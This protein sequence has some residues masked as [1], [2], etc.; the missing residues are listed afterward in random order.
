MGVIEAPRGQTYPTVGH[1]LTL[2]SG[3]ITPPPTYAS[4][5]V[6]DQ[7]TKKRPPGLL[8]GDLVVLWC[9]VTRFSRLGARGRW[10]F[11]QS[12]D[13]PNGYRTHRDTGALRQILSPT[14]SYVS[15]ALVAWLLNLGFVAGLSTQPRLLRILYLQRAGCQGRFYLDHRSIPVFLIFCS[16]F[17]R[18]RCC[19][20]SLKSL[21]SARCP[22]FS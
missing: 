1:L 2:I 14:T 19:F 21:V 13:S 22:F 11:L 16:F 7:Q 6:R 12:T 20:P 18:L 8:P 17:L 4:L 15:V 3:P 5:R 9:V 10:R